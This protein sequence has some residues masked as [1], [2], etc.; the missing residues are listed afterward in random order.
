[1]KFLVSFNLTPLFKHANLR[2]ATCIQYSIWRKI[3][4]LYSIRFSFCDIFVF[5]QTVDGELQD[6]LAGL[7]RT[8][9]IDAV[10]NNSM[11]RI[12]LSDLRQAAYEVN[13]SIKSKF[14][15]KCEGTCDSWLVIRQGV[16][17]GHIE[18][19]G[20]WWRMQSS[21]RLIE[22]LW[23]VGDRLHLRILLGVCLLGWVKILMRW[24][25]IVEL[26]RDWGVLLVKFH[27]HLLKPHL[28]LRCKVDLVGLHLNLIKICE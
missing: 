14:P 4:P 7:S 3:L 10:Q 1:M 12:P 6:T 25:L 20:V 16:D 28:L 21:L 15:F 11:L 24:L 13:W 8:G 9:L 23:L 5:N 2:F 22:H 17:L 18:L 19:Y 27:R 26:L